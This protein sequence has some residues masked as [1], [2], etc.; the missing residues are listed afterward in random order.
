MGFLD[1]V[2][3]IATKKIV[4]GVTDNVFRNSVVLA[5]CRKNC[6]EPYEGGPSWQ[7]NF[8]YGVLNP[9]AYTPGD[10][11]DISQVQVATGGTITPRYMNVPVPAYLEKLK[12]EMAGPTAVVNYVDLLLQTAA[13]TMSAKLSNDIFR[14]G[15]NQGTDRTKNINGLDEAFSDGTNNGFEATTFASYLTLTRTDVDSAL[16][17]PMT[18]PTAN[19]N[20]SISYPALEQAFQ[21]V[22]I[23]PEKPDLI[24]TSNLGWSYIKM[25]FQ[26]QQR[27]ET[28]TP[29]LG[30]TSFKFN[31]AD[32]VADQYCPGTRTATTADGKVGYSAVSGGETIWFMNT[33]FLRLYVST[34][35]LYGFGFTGFLPAQN[36]SVV[37]GHY[38]FCGNFTCTAPRLGRYLFGITG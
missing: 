7:E 8:L 5:Y 4:R 6:L 31:G 36:N 1:S 20:A 37:V 11:F 16:N 35:D 13:L 30:F 22:T 24:V 32:V 23:G 14:H 12:V 15:Q 27:F 26:A 21:S 28:T 29:E 10:T 25:A 17:S 3:T 18:S 19:V 38:R 34:D 2:N 9:T 33:K